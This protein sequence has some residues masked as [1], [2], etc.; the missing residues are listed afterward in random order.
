[1]SHVGPKMFILESK[2]QKIGQIFICNCQIHWPTPTRITDRHNYL[3]IRVLE[4][5][6]NRHSTLTMS[7][8]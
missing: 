6:R 5:N 7:M 3:K 4:A 8:R 2:M 1:L